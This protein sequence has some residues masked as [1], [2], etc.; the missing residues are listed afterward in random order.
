MNN[1]LSKIF[2]EGEVPAA[3]PLTK[4]R[5]MPQGKNKRWL[6]KPGY[7]WNPLFQHMERN[8]PCLCGSGS[9]WKRCCM[10]SQP[11]VV[12]QNVAD[13]MVLKIEAM[14]ARR[15]NPEP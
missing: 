4:P 10:Q 8:E 11:R 7:A 9:K 1:D 6:P 3:A 5:K 13:H 15:D 14:K 12:T 2:L